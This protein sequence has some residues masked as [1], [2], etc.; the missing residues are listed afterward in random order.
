MASIVVPVV[1]S[2]ILVMAIILVVLKFIT[3]KNRRKTPD[4]FR[5]RKK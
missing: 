1:V 2:V 4:F 5:E 3:E